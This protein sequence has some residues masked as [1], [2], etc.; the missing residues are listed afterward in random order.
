MPGL[1][2]LVWDFYF[3]IHGKYNAIHD[4]TVRLRTGSNPVDF[5]RFQSHTGKQN[6][7]KSS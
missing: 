5:N 4:L 7:W 1:T 2:K 6:G 3:N